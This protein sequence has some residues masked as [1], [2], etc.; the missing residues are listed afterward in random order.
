M[1]KLARIYLFGVLTSSTC[2]MKSCF[3]GVAVDVDEVCKRKVSAIHEQE[4][5]GEGQ[6]IDA[7]SCQPGRRAALH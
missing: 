7:P 2:R 4:D 3:M 5:L 6:R 1:K